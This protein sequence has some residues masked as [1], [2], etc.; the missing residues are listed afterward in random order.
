MARLQ[1]APDLQGWCFF[2][3][4]ADPPLHTSSMHKQ[5]SIPVSAC[6]SK[7]QFGA[8]LGIIVSQTSDYKD[9]CLVGTICADV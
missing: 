5:L 4:V 7:K 1:Q 2:T 3:Q 9:L 6:T 8:H